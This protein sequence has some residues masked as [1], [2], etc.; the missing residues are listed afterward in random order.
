MPPPQDPASNDPT[1]P[2]TTPTPGTSSSSQGEKAPSISEKTRPQSSTTTA[3]DDP[4]A[5]PPIAYHDESGPPPLH[6]TLKTHRRERYIVIFFSLLFLE[7]CVLPL[8]LFYSLKWGAHLSITKNLAIITSLIGAVSGF[9]IAQRTYFLWFKNGHESRRP[10]GAGRWGLD[11][12]HYIINFGL[13]AFFTPLI[14]GSS[15]SPASPE[16]TAMALPCFMLSQSIPMLISGL[17]PSHFRLPFRVSS[18]P[19]RH[20]LPPLTYTIVEDVIAVDGG[21]GLEFRQ[22]WRYR[23]ESSRIMRRLLRDIALYW[24]LSGTILG[25]GLIVIVWLAPTDTGYGLGYSMPWLW[26]MLSTVVTII[27]AKR[28]LKRERE[29][30]SDLVKVHKEKPLKLVEYQV[31]R[32]AYE[33][34]LARRSSTTVPRV[35]DP[36]VLEERALGGGGR[37]RSSPNQHR[38]TRSEGGNLADPRRT[39]SMDVTRAEDMGLTRDEEKKRPGHRKASKSMDAHI[40][41]SPDSLS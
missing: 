24:G 11:F 29:E 13:F 30:W 8:I 12:F 33:R 32:E 34:M 35:N 25:I 40:R 16:T 10:I 19:P 22:A 1:P 20:V 4:E 26:A 23:Y 36:V 3:V 37:A 27:W 21:G 28:E 39:A 15:L 31:D 17:F 2:S 41:P 7:S 38:R 9:K 5:P 6:Y 18:F 14:V